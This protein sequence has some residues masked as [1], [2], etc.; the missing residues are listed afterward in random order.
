MANDVSLNGVA[1]PYAGL[2]SWEGNQAAPNTPS[3]NI[4]AP[5]SKIGTNGIMAS[6]SPQQTP[7]GNIMPS[8]M[9]NQTQGMPAQSLN[10]MP[11]Q[12]QAQQAP[13]QKGLNN[14]INPNPMVQPAQLQGINPYAGVGY[15][16][17]N[18]AGFQQEQAALGAQGKV[19]EQGQ[20]QLG[21]QTAQNTQAQATAMQGLQKQ[22]SQALTDYKTQG[23]EFDSQ[24]AQVQAK[25]PSLSRDQVLDSYS[26]GQKA[27]MSLGTILGGI[28]AGMTHSSNQALEVINRN[29]DSVIASNNKNF[30]QSMEI[31]NSKRAKSAQDFEFARQQ[32]QDSTTLQNN[33][34]NAMQA[35]IDAQYKVTTSPAARLQL[36][37]ASAQVAQRMAAANQQTAVQNLQLQLQGRQWQAQMALNPR[38]VTIGTDAQGRP[39]Q[40]VSASDKSA[41]VLRE[42]VPQLDQKISAVKDMINYISTAPNAAGRDQTFIGKNLEGMKQNV[43][44]LFGLDPKELPDI[45]QTVGRD[46]TDFYNQLL[47]QATQ[48]KQNIINTHTLH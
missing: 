9:P 8:G 20:K 48:Q 27:V 21:Q 28:G 40:A 32:L 33:V 23:K 47:T 16:N 45:T 11:A 14:I 13:M 46:A 4:E 1:N 2:F 30:Q 5:I 29:V 18:P 19:L 22:S 43:G 3:P 12:Q 38:A 15:G 24:I 25:Y 37:A 17:I 34:F 6:A 35:K 26:T 42:Q 41:E 7:T 10:S 36:E 31:L 39:I 44:K